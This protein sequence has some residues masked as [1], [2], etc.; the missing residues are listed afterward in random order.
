MMRM[1]LVWASAAVDE[2]ASAAKDKIAIG[3]SRQ[4]VIFWVFGW[5]FM[6]LLLQNFLNRW[7]MTFHYQTFTNRSSPGFWLAALDGYE[8]NASWL[9]QPASQLLPKK[10]SS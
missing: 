8:A 4:W 9:F 3:L 2:K 6:G 5:V 1:T 10:D 7:L